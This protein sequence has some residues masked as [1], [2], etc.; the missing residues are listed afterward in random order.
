MNQLEIVI[1]LT[2]EKKRFISAASIYMMQEM[3][4]SKTGEQYKTS[5]IYAHVQKLR[6]CGLI[7]EGLPKGRA[8]TYYLSPKGKNFIEKTKER[9]II[10]ND[11]D[12]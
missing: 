8:K 7:L 4:K 3:I 6:V 11:D 2:L 12:N 1:L 9:G 5:T 10:E